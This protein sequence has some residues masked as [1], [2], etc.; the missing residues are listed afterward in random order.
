M[1][2][3]ESQTIKAIALAIKQS[4][5]GS[6]LLL[7]ILQFFL[8]TGMSEM[9]SQVQIMNIITHLH[10][11]QLNYP[12]SISIFF[13]TIFGFVTFDILP[14]DNI[15]GAIFDFDSEPYTETAAET[16][17]ESLYMIENTGCLLIFLF[18]ILV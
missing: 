18:L 8:N 11:M 3:E 13:G 6:L 17:Y 4:G 9:L 1:P 14:V 12:A 2:Y 15:Y 7:A 5:S 10:I 16:G